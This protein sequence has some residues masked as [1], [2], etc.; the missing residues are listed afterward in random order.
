[1]SLWEKLSGKNGKKRVGSG[2]DSGGG[3]NSGRSLPS[4]E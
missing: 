4:I 3:K 2:K 1:M